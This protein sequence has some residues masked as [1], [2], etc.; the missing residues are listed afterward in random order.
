MEH[1]LSYSSST[2][3]SIIRPSSRRHINWTPHNLISWQLLMRSP[4]MLPAADAGHWLLMMW[5]LLRVA[6]HELSLSPQGDS[7]MQ[8]PLT[9]WHPHPFSHPRGHR[10]LNRVDKKEYSSRHSCSSLFYEYNLPAIHT[11]QLNIILHTNYYNEHWEL[12][13]HMS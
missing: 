9:L 8:Q 10:V 4:V 1:C 2:A 3:D 5:L 13:W 11:L 12:L 6:G 7:R